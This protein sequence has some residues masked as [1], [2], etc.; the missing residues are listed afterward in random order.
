MTLQSSGVR[1][2][3][4]QSGRVVEFIAALKAVENMLTYWRN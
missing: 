3:I 4:V 1:I 2:E